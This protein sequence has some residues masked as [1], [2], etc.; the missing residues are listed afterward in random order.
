VSPWGAPVLFVKKKNGTLRL[1]VDYMGLNTLTIKNKYLL[2]LI[3]ELF[4]QLQGSC[5]YSKMDLR[6][7]YYQVRIKEEDIP[8][9][10][11]NTHY[12]HYKFVVMPFGVTNALAV[13]MDLMHRIFSPFL[14]KFVVIFIDDILIYSKSPEEHA[15][16]LK[17]VLEEL[18]KHKLYSKFSK[19]EFG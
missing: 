12:G 2:P 5:C 15:R 9:I 14:D 10:A 19:C 13:F 11:F 17:L 7:G 3:D 1:C 8:K 4:D 6:Q 16:H 18:R